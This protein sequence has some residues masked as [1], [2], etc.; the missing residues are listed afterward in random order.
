M[1]Q[2]RSM[3]FVRW[4]L[5]SWAGGKQICSISKPGS[6][7]CGLVSR[8]PEHSIMCKSDERSLGVNSTEI[9]DLFQ[10][11]SVAYASDCRKECS[12][13]EDCN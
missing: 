7:V 6:R 13:P 2:K 9:L 11:K 8:V 12:L 4:T 5:F 3:R 10:L 1:F